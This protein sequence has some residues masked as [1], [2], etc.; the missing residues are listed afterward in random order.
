MMLLMMII[1]MMQKLMLMIK[2][3]E[4]TLIQIKVHEKNRIVFCNCCNQDKGF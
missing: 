1:L 4:R 2:K 3:T